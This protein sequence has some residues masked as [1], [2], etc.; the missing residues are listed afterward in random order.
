MII[1]CRSD[2]VLGKRAIKKSI[3]QRAGLAPEAIGC[4][5]LTAIDNTHI[6]IENHG[7]ISE[8]TPRRVGIN[9]GCFYI[10]VQGAGMELESFGQENVSIKG[11]I[12]SITYELSRQG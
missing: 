1:Y 7:S 11:E 5:R 2:I 10:V 8:Y 9:A 4:V 6:C 3:V 12:T